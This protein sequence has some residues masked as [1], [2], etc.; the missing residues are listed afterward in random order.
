MSHWP[1][2]RIQLHDSNSRVQVSGRLRLPPGG[3]S[4]LRAQYPR[5]LRGHGGLRRGGGD[6]VLHEVHGHAA[7]GVPLPAQ[8]LTD[9]VRRHGERPLQA[10]AQEIQ[11]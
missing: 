6:A 4:L 9:R 8:Q 11:E 1:H 7:D 3:W 2:P 10:R 5:T